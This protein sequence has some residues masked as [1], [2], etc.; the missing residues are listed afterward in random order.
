MSNN[1]V[2]KEKCGPKSSDT[3]DSL[4]KEIAETKDWSKLVPDYDEDA[5]M[6]HWTS[7]S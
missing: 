1:S 3:I 6:V 2:P 5:L 4:I 7:K